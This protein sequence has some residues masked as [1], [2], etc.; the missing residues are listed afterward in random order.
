[1]SIEFKD[2][3]YP[4]TPL[5][6]D[7]QI[8]RFEIIEDN[9][10]RTNHKL[11]IVSKF[12]YGYLFKTDL[13]Y[14]FV[15][16]S[17]TVRN[18]VDANGIIRIS[19]SND[20]IYILSFDEK[21]ELNVYDYNLEFIETLDVKH[22]SENTVVFKLDKERYATDIGSYH[23]MNIASENSSL[24]R[25][26]DVGYTD[27]YHFVISSFLQSPVAFYSLYTNPIYDEYYFD[28]LYYKEFDDSEYYFFLKEDSSHVLLNYNPVSER[29]VSMIGYNNNLLY[30]KERNDDKYLVHNKYS[31]TKHY[32]G[33]ETFDI[34]TIICEESGWIYM[35]DESSEILY[36]V[37]E[38]EL[39]KI[40]V[41]P[42]K[43]VLIII[44]LF[45]VSFLFLFVSQDEKQNNYRPRKQETSNN[46]IKEHNHPLFY[47]ES[48]ILEESI[49]A[50]DERED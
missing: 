1:M 30:I 10:P 13:T 46:L 37:S 6:L 9:I 24:F 11:E 22:L 42:E 36:K 17:F 15:D 23:L 45:I 16:N 35:Y 38:K 7:D 3:S 43:N 31:E 50:Y 40:I 26:E 41:S 18:T 49:K 14:Y 48:Q 2:A 28:G 25:I 29:M 44:S 47:I 8:G 34:R 33:L 27:G 4:V 19:Y 5:F 12:K 39:F 32:V 20:E 21:Y